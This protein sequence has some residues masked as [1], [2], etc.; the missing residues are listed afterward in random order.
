MKVDHP[1]ATSA[2]TLTYGKGS[3]D[4]ADGLSGCIEAINRDIETFT[5]LAKPYVQEKYTSHMKTRTVFN[6]QNII[7]DMKTLTRSGG[8]DKFSKK[9]SER[10]MYLKNV[11]FKLPTPSKYK[12]LGKGDEDQG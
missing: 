3:K 9:Q 1:D 10:D 5:N 2:D 7:K 8:F 6:K 11:D 4:I 12:N